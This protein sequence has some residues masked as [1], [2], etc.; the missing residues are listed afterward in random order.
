MRSF[1]PYHFLLL[2][3][4][5]VGC[6]SNRKK[7]VEYVTLRPTDKNPY[8]TWYAYEELKWLFPK[9]EVIKFQE[10]KSAK[11]PAAT[12]VNE[13]EYWT[14]LYENKGHVAQLIVSPTAYADAEQI[15]A[16]VEFINY[17]NHLFLTAFD[18]NETLL[19]SL[20]MKV[21][22]SPMNF[23]DEDSLS[24]SLNHPVTGL[25][26]SF[27]Y[28]GRGLDRYFSKIDTSHIIVLGTNSKGKPNFVKLEYEN[29]ASLYVHL[30]PLA[31]SNFFL[32][33]RQNKQY[34]D[35]AL[36][37]LPPDVKLITWTKLERK[38]DS[39]N[40][41]SALGWLMKQKS[42]STA[43]WLLLLLMAIVYLFESKRRQR[44]IPDIAPLRNASLDFVKTIGRLYFQRKDNNNLANKMMAHFLDH[45]RTRYNIR[46]TTLDNEFEQRLSYKSGYPA[47]K[48]Q[49]L[50][51][52]MQQVQNTPEAPDNLLLDLNQQLE[53]FYAYGK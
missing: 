30:A 7:L 38:E 33:H 32:L 21:E 24:V 46:A 15:Q 25:S 22:L 36:S 41:F 34:F 45:V 52:L 11:K 9:A 43:L 35:Q 20:Q 8:G 2:L 27:H 3:T 12:V 40:S 16:A 5:I 14:K 44:I 6:N 17:G 10:E 19:D 42:L 47:E 26:D 13:N 31:F 4:L 23:D 53:Q 1:K 29:G 28:P 51:Y 39:P 48:V 49:S 18:I 50:V 37:Y